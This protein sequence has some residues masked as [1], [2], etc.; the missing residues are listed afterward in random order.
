MSPSP[1]LVSLAFFLFLNAI[2]G[3]ATAQLQTSNISFVFGN[4]ACNSPDLPV[5]P[6]GITVSGLTA[7]GIGC[8]AGGGHIS[9]LWTSSDQV[10]TN[11]Y[12]GFSIA[13]QEG[14]MLSF[15]EL[16]SLSIRALSGN[17][18]RIQPVYIRDGQSHVLGDTALAG[19]FPPPSYTFPIED[20]FETDSLEI[21]IYGYNSDCG[22]LLH[23]LEIGLTLQASNI[24]VGIE[25]QTTR[26]ASLVGAH[27]FPN[28]VARDATFSFSVASPTKVGLVIY[29]LLGR[30]VARP[31][32]SWLSEGSHIFQW[33]ARSRPSG[34]YVYTLRAGTQVVT[35]LVL[36]AR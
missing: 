10:N 5:H 33:D 16:D 2:P 3:V 27:V 19:D 22:G 30:E 14:E 1:F 35:G 18:I 24:R 7:E 25:D 6:D 28:P 17:G 8:H 26:P 13:A 12:L 11:Q 23:V 9:R 21:R 34:M 32:D 4:E 31:V 20:S 29:D 15:S 36:V